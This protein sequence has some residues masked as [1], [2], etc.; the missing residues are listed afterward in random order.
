MYILRIS[1]FHH[2]SLACVIKDGEIL[3]AM[4]KEKFIKKKFNI[5]FQ[6]TQ[7]CNILRKIKLIYK[8]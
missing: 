1:A 4:Q 3:I 7:F 6:H 8:I 5:F 2:D